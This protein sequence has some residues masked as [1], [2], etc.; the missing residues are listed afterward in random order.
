LPKLDLSFTIT[1]IVALISLI[2][3]IIT[4]LLNNR[5]QLKIR[6][7]ELAQ[8]HNENTVL[9][10]RNIFENYVS[11]LSKVSSYATVESITEYGKYY[12]LA[13]MY[14]PENLQSEMSKINKLV[15]AR[16]YDNIAPLLEDLIP[17]IYKVLQTM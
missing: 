14:L 10:M 15:I 3:P 1:A 2:S 9:Y 5:H 6:K 7:L 12:S 13:Y 4:T 11:A 16:D 8:K 17:K